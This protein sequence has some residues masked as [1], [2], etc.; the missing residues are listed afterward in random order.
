M[1]W[2]TCFLFGERDIKHEVIQHQRSIMQTA[3]DCFLYSHITSYLVGTEKLLLWDTALVQSCLLPGSGWCWTPPGAQEWEGSWGSTFPVLQAEQHLQCLPRAA[4]VWVGVLIHLCKAPLPLAK[5]A[6]SM[7][8]PS[9]LWTQ[10]AFLPLCPSR[11]LDFYAC[12]SSFQSCE[13]I[14]AVPLLKA[15]HNQGRL[16]FK[17]KS[18]KGNFWLISVSRCLKHVS[19]CV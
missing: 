17:K 5:S 2:S 1:C 4:R 19:L 14:S 7:G 10:A 16:F 13:S 3:V 18:F 11:H 12:W 8:Q 6:V 15:K 9:F